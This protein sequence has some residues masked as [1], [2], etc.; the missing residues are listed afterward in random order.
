M[1]RAMRTLGLSGVRRR[2]VTRT[3]VPG[4]DGTRAGDLLDRS[5]SAPASNRL[6]VSDFTYVCAWAGFPYVAFIVDVLAQKIVA[7]HASSAQAADGRPVG[8]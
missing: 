2:K 6:W 3:T 8:H 4:K 7:W 1:N 5:F